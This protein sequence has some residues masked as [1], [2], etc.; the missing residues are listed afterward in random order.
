[1]P[2]SIAL[3][4]GLYA[5]A[6]PPAPGGPVSPIAT[7]E[8]I[9][10]AVLL[11]KTSDYADAT[12]RIGVNGN[13]WVV[14][15]TMPYN[16]ATF[17]PT[18]I[19]LSV[20]DPGY[21]GTTTTIV[22]RTI[23]G[24]AVLRRQ[25]T[26]QTARQIANDGVTFTV[27]FSL[28]EDVYQGTTIVSATAAASFY[29]ASTAGAIISPTN[30]STIAYPKPLAAWVNRQHERATGSGFDV[31]LVAYHLHARNGQQ[32]ARVEFI[33][34]DASAH[35]AATQTATAPALSAFQTQG[36]I[37]EAYK[38]TIPLSA[39]TQ[40]DLCQVNAK[41]YPW[42]GDSSAIL[43]LSTDGI[44]WPTAQTQTKLRFCNDKA[45]TY[46]GAIVYV[47]A[48]G[49]DTTGVASLTDATAKASPVATLNGALAKAKSFN[50][51]SRGHNDHSG[52][53]IYLMDNAGAAYDHIPTG[54][55]D[56]STGGLCWTHVRKDPLAVGAVRLKTH[57]SSQHTLP[58]L[59]AFCCD[60]LAYANFSS[61]INIGNVMLSLEG[62]T[63]LDTSNTVSGIPLGYRFGLIY[64][65]NVTYTG[66]NGSFTNFAGFSSERTQC[67]LGL[68]VIAEGATGDSTIVT[69]HAIIGCRLKRHVLGEPD[70]I[71]FQPNDDPTDGC[72]IANNWFR[73]CRVPNRAGANAYSRG[74]AIVQNVFERSVAAV[75][76]SGLSLSG[77]STTNAVANVIFQY[78]TIPGTDESGRMNVSYGDT[79]GAA[80]VVKRVDMKFNLLSTYNV[81]TDAFDN[82]GAETSKGRVGGWRRAYCVN[83]IGNVVTRGDTSGTPGTPSLDGVGYLGMAW[84]AATYAVGTG[85]VT[86]T[87]DK[88]GFGGAGMGT[89]SLT[90]GS[91]AAYAKVPSGF[92]GLKYDIASVARLNN[93]NG[94]VGAYE[95]P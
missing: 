44:T 48:T 63:S 32:V 59:V 84:P 85:N 5:L 83:D 10:A 11:D 50:N 35:T 86:Y 55:M 30:N 21:D 9:S 34:A 89:Y 43:D 70:L 71:S 56:A 41:V 15:A 72:V 37:V 40:A 57:A 29:G 54:N 82:A 51:S 19:S 77:D 79:A 38:A 66:S 14:K 80:G 47:S 74:I 67:A 45:G 62:I 22:S 49:N 36:N 2:L 64:Q 94:A 13:G 60:I 65:R 75:S 73:S 27:Y 46:G 4:M 76:Q 17:D 12:A 28:S 7:F 24:R 87:D 91:N 58:S 61:G 1:M 88:S 42:I 52:A 93:G 18:K 16:A 26:Q 8:V 39:L 23:T 6:N 90:G 20:T 3:R 69:T 31:E 53:T 95:R 33:A 81:K 78:N 25:Y 92:S 68:G